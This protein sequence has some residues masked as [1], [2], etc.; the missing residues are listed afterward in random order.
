MQLQLTLSDLTA[1]TTK[2]GLLV[3]EAPD[4]PR[5]LEHTKP[6]FITWLAIGGAYAVAISPPT[7]TRS[8]VLCLQLQMDGC[9]TR[10][11]SDQMA[12]CFSGSKGEGK[13]WLLLGGPLH[14]RYGPALC[15]FHWLQSYPLSEFSDSVCVSLCVWSLFVYGCTQ[16][17]FLLLFC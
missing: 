8:T 11:R 15:G 10:R 1:L 5:G 14:T 17:R 4:I 13:I 9:V 2:R 12:I 3:S 16:T 7:L 6:L